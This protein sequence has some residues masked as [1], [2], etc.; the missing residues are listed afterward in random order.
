LAKDYKEE[1]LQDAEIFLSSFK[2]FMKYCKETS[3]NKI[4]ADVNKFWNILC[5][6]F[7]GKDK[8]EEAIKEAENE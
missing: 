6:K 7:G 3:E 2:D 5:K 1:D 4:L 8:V